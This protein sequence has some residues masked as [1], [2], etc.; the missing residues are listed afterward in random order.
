MSN[1]CGFLANR[2]EEGTKNTHWLLCQNSTARR[3]YPA[4][5]L[6]HFQSEKDR[7]RRQGQSHLTPS[8]CLRVM[9][10]KRD[11]APSAAPDSWPAAGQ[12]RGAAG[13]TGRAPR[14]AGHVVTA[15]AQLQ[16]SG[17]TARQCPFPRQLAEAE[18]ERATQLFS[19]CFSQGAGDPCGGVGEGNRYGKKAAQ[20]SPAHLAART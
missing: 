13:G 15:P 1:D 14:C 4:N 6:K 7:S 19:S 2:E 10:R 11:R 16:G 9:L 17:S 18:T 12:A 5:M 8:G 3:T 20:V